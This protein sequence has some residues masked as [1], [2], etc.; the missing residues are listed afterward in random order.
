MLYVIIDGEEIL[1]NKNLNS[2]TNEMTT[3]EAL[4]GQIDNAEYKIRI[5]E[6]EIKSK[7]S[8]IDNFEYECSDDEYDEMIDDCSDEVNIFG[9][10]YS[11][12]QVLKE[13]DPVAYRCGKSDYESNFDLDDCEEY[14]DMVEQLE[15]LNSELV[16]L[17]DELSDLQDELDN[18]ESEES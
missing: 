7:Q 8:E 6:S 1:V 13:L 11:P 17:Q 15:S 4:K 3:I 9:M 10:T 2:E 18:L 16:S 5:I 12:S 14:T